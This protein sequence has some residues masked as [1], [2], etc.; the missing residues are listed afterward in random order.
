[1]YFWAMNGEQILYLQDVAGDEN[2]HLYA[3][4]LATGDRRDLTPFESVQTRVTAIARDRP[5]ELLVAVNDRVPELHDVW[6]INTRTGD[7]SL[8][9]QNDA[10]FL[11]LQAD[12]DYRVRVASRME[13]DGGMRVIARDAD[14]APWYELVR[15]GPEDNMTSG[16]L[17]FTRDGRTLYVLDSRGV[18]TAALHAYTVDEDGTARYEALASDPRADV[19]EV[20]FD[21]ETGE[22]QEVA[23]DYAR[24][25]W[26]ILDE[27]IRLDWTRLHDAA[28]GEMSILSRDR[29]DNSWI[30]AF[31]RDTGPVAYYLYRRDT[32]TVTFLFTNRPELEGLPLAPMHPVVIRARDGLKLVSYL[33]L[34]PASGAPAPS[35]TDGRGVVQFRADGPVRNLP[36]ILLVHGGPWARDSWGYNSM[37]QWLAN[38]G[39]AVLSVN[40]RG[41]TGFG[42]AFLNAGNREWAGRMH[43]DLI[44]AVNWAVDVGVADPD[45]VAIMGGSYGG[46]AT[47]VGLTFTPEFFAAGVDIVGPSHVRTLIESI[48]PYWKP[49]VAMFED[50]VGRADEH[51]HLDSISPLTRVDA[52][53]RPLLIAQGANDP[54]VKEAESRQIVDAMQA[55][56][57]PVTYVLFPDEGHGFARPTN[58][59]AFFAVAESFLG[60]HLGGRV[61]PI[62]SAVRESSAEVEAG[63]ELVPGLQ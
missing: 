43:D 18:D 37:H 8:V 32:G 35:V 21:P 52:I 34:P 50:R 1:M 7:R 49:L 44:D 53:Q 42:K 51:D 22:P 63:A 10:G 58:S 16:P 46:Y 19:A 61:E 2:F 55:K 40:F 29:A 4:D 24:R 33:T 11:N 14:D 15:W 39:Y 56:G 27:S 28:E 13:P 62:G 54:R 38:R 23:F 57:L 31:E 20:E 6:S 48:P 41:S 60:E 12:D 45:R 26:K 59:L 25:E 9:F 3:V 17:S 47:L 36:M 30:V 5:N